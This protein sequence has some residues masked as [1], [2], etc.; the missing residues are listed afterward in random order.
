MA[1]EAQSPLK[2]FNLL[3]HVC[4]FA[5]QIQKPD[6]AAHNKERGKIKEKHADPCV[7]RSFCVTVVF[8][9]LMN[10]GVEERG[11]V[12]AFEHI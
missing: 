4:A 11:D 2:T 6:G 7:G 12:F 8:L 5:K 9:N 10:G 3:M 1:H